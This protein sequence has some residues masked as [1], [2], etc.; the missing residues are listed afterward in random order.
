MAYIK[1]RKE[2]KKANSGEDG[3]SLVE[4]QPGT[5]SVEISIETLQEQKLEPS[6]DLTVP[7]LENACRNQC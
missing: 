4:M 1:K 5:V 3:E 2:K 7:R 6:F